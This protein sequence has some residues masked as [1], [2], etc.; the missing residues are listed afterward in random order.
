MENREQATFCKG[1]C[2]A[3]IVLSGMFG[4]F[5]AG[6]ATAQ[7][8]DYGHGFRR[9]G[10]VDVGGTVT[11]G[12]ARRD[13]AVVGHGN[14][15]L[16]IIEI[17]DNGSAMVVSVV[18]FTDSPDDVVLR[19][20]TA[21]VACGTAGLRILDVSTPAFPVTLAV[22]ENPGAAEAVAVSGDLLFL[23]TVATFQVIDIADPARPEV[24]GSL[25][26]TIR[27]LDVQ[28]D[29]VYGCSDSSDLVTIIDVSEP[30]DPVVAS[31]YALTVDPLDID[32]E[33][34]WAYVACDLGGLRAFN[35]ADPAAPVYEGF[36]VGFWG[37]TVQVHGDVAWVGNPQEGLSLVD[38]SDP[39]GLVVIG[40]VDGHRAISVDVDDDRVMVGDVYD[41][42]SVYDMAGVDLWNLESPTV[43][44]TLPDIGEVVDVEAGDQ[45]G[46]IYTVNREGVIAAHD[47]SDPANPITLDT[48]PWAGGHHGLDHADGRLYVANE[49]T[50]LLVCDAS[51]PADLIYLGAAHL[52]GIPHDVFAV[53]DVVHVAVPGHGLFVVDVSDPS[54][55]TV[56]GDAAVGASGLVVSDG[57]AYTVAHATGLSILEVGESGDP[58]L[59]SNLP[60]PDI[61]EH[62]IAVQG[63]VAYV[64]SRNRLWVVDVEDRQ[65]PRLV[66]SISLL[67][68]WLYGEACLWGLTIVDDHLYAARGRNGLQVI[69]ISSPLAPCVLGELAVPER[70]LD[71]VIEGDFIY[72]AAGDGGLAVGPG[73]CG[74][75]LSVEPGEVP[76]SLAA[77]RSY[78]NPFNPMTVIEFTLPGAGPA[79]VTIH[80]LGGRLVTRLIEGERAAGQHDIVWRGCDGAGRTVPSGIYVARLR[81]R[82]VE[83]SAKLMLV[84]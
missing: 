11:C 53:G 42:L 30:S 16:E 59:L 51:D 84:R 9:I 17:T 4:M 50:R 15:E 5:S 2:L 70:C 56:I 78:P 62:G 21:F 77:L 76:T 12:D 61:F 83:A 31:T 7:C 32:V 41:G 44:G 10:S 74:T 82:G 47:V 26:G 39:S 37:Q 19:D 27:A 49:V 71:T 25:P 24:L 6:Q 22:L 58:V 73:Q 54:A 60:I 57:F 66:T 48:L 72:M 29:H 55:P 3:I 34:E 63:D 38:V 20:N 52:P 64:G 79:T 8:Y 68:D 67:P 75:V 14:G 18:T 80:D 33:G 46:V 40:T 69:D 13:L 28:D 43:L 81:A 35:V 1:W 23:G 45:A 36:V 65:Q